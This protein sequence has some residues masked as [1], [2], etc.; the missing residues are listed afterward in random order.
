MVEKGIAEEE[1]PRSN[2]VLYKTVQ[3]AATAHIQNMVVKQKAKP[4]KKGSAKI[5]ELVAGCMKRSW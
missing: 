1:T 2:G 5:V 3:L 4:A